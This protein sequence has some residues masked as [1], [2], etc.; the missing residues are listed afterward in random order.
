A[1][2]LIDLHLVENLVFAA[3][4]FAMA[5]RRVRAVRPWI[6]VPAAIALLYYDSRLPGLA[7]AFSQAGLVASFS[8]AYLWELAG[9]FVSWKVIALVVVAIGACVAIGRIVRLDAVV[10]AAM[11]VLVLAMPKP[12]AVTDEPP[13]DIAGAPKGANPAAQGPDEMLAEFFR[14]ESQRKVAFARPAGTAFD[15]IF[16][17]V[18]SLS[19]DDLEATGLAQHPLLSGFDILLKRFNSVSTYSG[20]AA[21]RLLRAPCG[22]PRH[23]A[24]WTPAPAQCLL[25]P[26]LQQA[27]LE[28]QLALNHDGHFDGFL[29][30]VRAQ[31]ML[32]APVSLKGIEAPQRGFDGSRIYDDAAV[33]KRWLEAR[34]KSPAPRAALYYN[35]LSLHDG[36][37]MANDP[38]T[39]SSDTYKMRLGR[40]LDDLK[41]FMDEL[42]ASGRRAVVV[43]IPEHGAAIRG[44]DG[45]IAGLREIPTPAITLVPVGIRVIG[46]DAQRAGAP[47]QS[48]EQTS[49][50]ALSHIVSAMLA[51]PPFG[52]PFKAADYTANMP[53]TP[54]VAEGEA[55]TVIRKGDKYLLRR[56]QEAWT[57]IR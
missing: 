43:L 36:N 56:E 35:T 12:K 13:V 44:A 17:H 23:V 37:H 40:L 41:K 9:R 33:L 2:G 30:H 38:Y 20:P 26:E 42:D 47:V 25:M 50:L 7:R 21:I 16:I 15:V 32:A 55:A 54:Y 19:W 48:E 52:D 28:P 1:L 51:K 57:E 46:P 8:G 4:L 22:Q 34:A 53:V 5:D 18:C 10:V 49:F 39:K 31:S 11:V 3:A 27:G 14:A 6:G 24:L 29:D 45:Q